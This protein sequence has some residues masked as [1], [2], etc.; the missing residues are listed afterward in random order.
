[1]E[2]MAHGAEAANTLKVQTHLGGISGYEDLLVVWLASFCISKKK[3]SIIVVNDNM[4]H[5]RTGIIMEIMGGL[6]VILGS[7]S[8]K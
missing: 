3:D 6:G 2:M 7:Y 8:T 5:N 4:V 1:M